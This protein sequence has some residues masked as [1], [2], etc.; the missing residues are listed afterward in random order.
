MYMYF[1]PERALYIRCTHY[2]GR[3]HSSLKTDL[4]LRSTV[5]FRD[6]FY[7]SEEVGNT[8]CF[9]TS[10]CEVSVYRVERNRLICNYLKQTR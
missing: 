7:I 1:L 3:I 8:V 6:P 10:Q 9:E 5:T 2:Q 4:H